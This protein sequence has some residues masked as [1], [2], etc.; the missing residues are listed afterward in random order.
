VTVQQA[1]AGRRFRPDGARKELHRVTGMHKRKFHELM[2]HRLHEIMLVL[3]IIL[4]GLFF[5]PLL[6]SPRKITIWDLLDPDEAL[7]MAMLAAFVALLLLTTYK[8]ISERYGRWRLNR[9]LRINRRR[10]VLIV[11]SSVPFDP[12]NQ[13]QSFKDYFNWTTPADGIEGVKR[14]MPLFERIGIPQEMVT[15]K[16]SEKVNDNE[17]R[18]CNLF[19][20]GGHEHNSVARRLNDLTL[21][22][23][24]VIVLKDNKIILPDSSIK[25]TQWKKNQAGT[26]EPSLDYGLVTRGV[27]RFISPDGHRPCVMWAFEGVRHWGTLAGIDIVS[28][29]AYRKPYKTLQRRCRAL[30]Y[31]PDNDRF[32]QFVVSCN[33]DS[34]HD[35]DFDHKIDYVAPYIRETLM[36]KIGAAVRKYLWLA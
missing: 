23:A 10:K 9:I 19:L 8:V 32:V 29:I 36:R 7:H 20:I 26:D 35:I 6:V 33:V 14:L 3:E 27:N 17:L 24:G 13:G 30:K 11:L 25:E 34:A 2:L 18:E 5:S 12:P 15:F 4:L 21:G 28:R 16:F 31:R 1:A 22:R